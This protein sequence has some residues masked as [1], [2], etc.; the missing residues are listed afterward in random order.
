MPLMPGM[1][2]GMMGPGGPQPPQAMPGGAP[3]G[4]PGMMPQGGPPPGQPPAPL[5]PQVLQQLLARGGPGGPGGQ[6]PMPEKLAPGD[7][8]PEANAAL[9]LALNDPSTRKTLAA[10]ALELLT[11]GEGNMRPPGPTGRRDAEPQGGP[12]LGG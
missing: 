9:E 11:G 12:L 4:P 1:P 3:G 8:D 5:P 10:M 6:P 2:P 7:M